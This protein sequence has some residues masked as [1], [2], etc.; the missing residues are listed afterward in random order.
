MVV[1][2]LVVV[3]VASC[4]LSGCGTLASN[5]GILRGNI[6]IAG[7]TAL[8]PLATQAAK[9]YMQSHAQVKISVSERR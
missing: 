9:L 5:Q 6:T 8:Y 1:P 7:S 4:L 2:L 3:V